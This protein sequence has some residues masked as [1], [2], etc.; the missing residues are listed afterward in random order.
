M[1]VRKGRVADMASTIQVKS[2]L[3]RLILDI[4]LCTVGRL[5]FAVSVNVLIA[6]LNL[7]SVGFTGIAQLLRTFCLH[8]L[9]IQPPAGLDL[10]GIIFCLL[11][12]PVLFLAWFGIGKRFFWKTLFITVISSI[13]MAV[14]PVPSTPL[15]E[16]TLT[17]CIVGGIMAG[18]GA[19]VALTAGGSGGGQDVLGVYLS[20][21]HPNMSVGLVSIF[22]SILVY[23][24]CF[25]YF[26]LRVLLYSFIYSTITS[27]ALDRVYS[28][29]IKLLVEIETENSSLCLRLAQELN[30]HVME[31]PA[32]GED[33]HSCFRLSLVITKAEQNTLLKLVRAEDRDAFVVFSEQIHISGYFAKPIQ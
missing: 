4:L 20:K 25:I 11:N 23:A 31:L 17:V 21:K 10:T 3:L 16:D 6:P 8:I 22:I 5:L 24:A 30:R 33:G 12:I 1:R 29:N 26:D 32:R 28:Q 15:L 19:G 2:R 18:V 7:Y 14:I 13:F 9:Q 27:L